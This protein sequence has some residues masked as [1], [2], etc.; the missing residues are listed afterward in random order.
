M[1]RTNAVFRLSPAGRIA[2]DKRP[3]DAI[4]SYGYWRLEVTSENGTKRTCR[5][6]RSMSASTAAR[7]REC[8]H[9]GKNHGFKITQSGK[10]KKYEVTPAE[11]RSI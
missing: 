4:R 6:A 8:Q 5:R 1:Y 11:A 2:I 7:Y 10:P 9:D 3:A